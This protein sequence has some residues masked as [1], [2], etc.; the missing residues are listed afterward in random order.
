MKNVALLLLSVAIISCNKGK[1]E[2][3]D[4]KLYRKSKNQPCLDYCPG[5]IGCDGKNYCS[6]CYAAQEGIKAY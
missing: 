3:Y 5:A 4:A 2:C 1:H 6:S